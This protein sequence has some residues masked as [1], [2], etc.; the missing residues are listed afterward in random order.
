[1]IFAVLALNST[2]PWQV[3]VHIYVC[4]F[5]LLRMCCRSHVLGCSAFARQCYCGAKELVLDRQDSTIKGMSAGTLRDGMLNTAGLPGYTW[6]S[7]WIV[8]GER[9]DTKGAR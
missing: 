1:M 5:R 8:A 2:H 6:A 7:W 4:R 9:G 3:P